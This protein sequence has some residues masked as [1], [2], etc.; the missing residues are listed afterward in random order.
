MSKENPAIE[1]S[2]ARSKPLAE[3]RQARRPP[4]PRLQGEGRGKG[5]GGADS[6]TSAATTPSPLPVSGE[7][8][9]ARALI[10]AAP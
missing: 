3:S 8:G 1:N 6:N 2:Y 4:C 10:D 5:P 7:R 9:L